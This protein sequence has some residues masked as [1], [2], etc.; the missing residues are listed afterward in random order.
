MVLHDEASQY[1]EKSKKNKSQLETKG[2]A[3]SLFFFSWVTHVETNRVN[4]GIV[5][6]KQSLELAIEL[7]LLELKMNS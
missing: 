5:L 4:E 2:M 3:N 6:C 1:F 7:E